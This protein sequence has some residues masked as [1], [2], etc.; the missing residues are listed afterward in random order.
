[1]N[2]KSSLLQLIAGAGA[3]AN[4]ESRPSKSTRIKDYFKPK[5]WAARKNKIKQQKKSRKINRAA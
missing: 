3:L 2:M 1:M 5:Q 4:T